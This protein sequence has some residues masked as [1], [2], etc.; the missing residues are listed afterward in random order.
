MMAVEAMAC[1]VPVIVADGTAL[2]EVVAAP[3][4]GVSVRQGDPGALASAVGALLADP[5]A[6]RRRGA[7]GR[8][9]AESRYSFE[10]YLDAHLRLYEAAARRRSR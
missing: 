9:L 5:A 3:Q 2:P 8:A 4:V 7:A 6:R 1:G 10:Q